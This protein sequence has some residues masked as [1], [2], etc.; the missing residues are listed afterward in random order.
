MATADKGSNRRK[1]ERKDVGYTFT[2]SVDGSYDLRMNLGA[3]EDDIGALM[4]NL[5]DLGVAIVTNH[6]FPI[7]TKLILK[8]NLMNLNLTGEARFRH[9]KANG[10]VTYSNIFSGLNYRIGV[11]F[12]EISEKDKEA[13]REFVK[14]SKINGGGH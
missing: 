6:D 1:S 3:V 4:L 7:G 9:I 14:L 12:N 13:I 5:S 8:F 10:E 11:C 2:Y